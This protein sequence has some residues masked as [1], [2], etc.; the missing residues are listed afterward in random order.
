MGRC[1]NH[2]AQQTEHHQLIN[3]YF[4]HLFKTKIKLMSKIFRGILGGFSGLVGTVVGADFRGIPIMKIRPKKPTKPPVQSQIDQR[5]QFGL[6]TSFLGPLGDIIKIAFK[7]KTQYL[8]PMNTAVQYNL[9]NAII[10]SSPSFAIDYSKIKVS[11]GKL[12]G[13]VPLTVVPVAGNKLTVTW[14]KTDNG[15]FEPEEK[16]IRDKDTLRLATYCEQTGG[17][18]IAGYTTL[19][20]AGTLTTRLP[21]AEEGDEVHVWVVLVSA[22]K[23]AVSSSQYL[24]K[25][26]V[27]S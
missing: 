4:N 18:Y 22:D 24:G 21:N 11:N 9:Q 13:I 19:R 6:I 10:G 12:A 14:D 15:S 27:L 26:V 17:Y 1:Y 3:L 5:S 20:S 7:P 23:K 25:V 16:L 8:S 2:L